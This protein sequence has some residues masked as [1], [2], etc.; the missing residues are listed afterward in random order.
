VTVVEASALVR[1]LAA[2]DRSDVLFARLLDDADLH[3]PHLVDVEV[4]HALR[5]LVAIG[6]LGDD[7]AAD[8]RLDLDAL[9]ITRYPHAA[10][11]DR[12]WELRHG[13]SVYDAVYVSLAEALDAPLITC[14][15]R[16]ARAPGIRATVELF[17]SA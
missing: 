15:R 8:A 4:T 17:A 1:V 10:L 11:L 12:A 2:R 9:P 3:A 6:E 7:R 14:D 13:L 5:R 16:L